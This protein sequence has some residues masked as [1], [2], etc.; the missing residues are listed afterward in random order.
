[1]GLGIGKRGFIKMK[2]IVIHP[3]HGGF[4]VSR[5]AFLELRKLKNPIALKEAD[6]GEMW[7]DGSG[8]RTSW[9][10]MDSFCRDISRDDKQLIEVLERIKSK[11]DPRFGPLKIV[12]IPDDVEWV[13]EEYDGAEWVAEK[14]RTW[15]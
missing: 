7:E 6:I 11:G 13:I 9:A 12:E 14:H 5:D 15:E 1:M 8:P 2:K 10:G 4:G 3:N